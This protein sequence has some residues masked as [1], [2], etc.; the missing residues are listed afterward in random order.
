MKHIKSF[1]QLNEGLGYLTQNLNINDIMD[2]VENAMDNIENYESALMAAWERCKKQHKYVRLSR[3]PQSVVMHLLI[4]IVMVVSAALVG[5]P[6]GLAIGIIFTLLG[7]MKVFL[8][9]AQEIAKA[10]PESKALKQEIEWLYDCLSND[11]AVISL[12]KK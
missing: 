2:N 8:M 11:K 10:G 5:G 7:N 12:F 6:P 3:L 9:M 4:T 1:W